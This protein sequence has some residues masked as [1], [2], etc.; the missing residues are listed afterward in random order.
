[1]PTYPGG[2]SQL[3]KDLNANLVYP[4]L[5]KSKGIQGIVFVQFYV[6]KDG[7]ISEVKVARGIKDGENLDKEAVE[8]VKKLKNFTPAK[9]HKGEAVR[10]MLTLPVRFKLP[11][12]TDVKQNNKP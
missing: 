2:D 12:E 5:E 9:N 4:K 10:T 3:V 8:T 7:S 6:E 11:K 1:M